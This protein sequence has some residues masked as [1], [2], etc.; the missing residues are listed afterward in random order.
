MSLVQVRIGGE[1]FVVFETM[2]YLCVVGIVFPNGRVF[3]EGID[4]VVEHVICDSLVS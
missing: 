2:T 1:S 4:R 3:V